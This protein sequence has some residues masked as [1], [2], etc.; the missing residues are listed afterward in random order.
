M[1]LIVFDWNPT[2]GL[3]LVAN[4]DEF[5]A[6]PSAALNW[7]AEQP[8]ILA[9]RDLQAG[10]SWLGL[11]RQGRFAAITNVREAGAETG[12]RSRGHLVR[13][14]LA[15]SSS[16]HVW[17]EDLEPQAYPGFNLLL[18]A[19]K[20]LVYISN[21]GDQGAQTLA[22]GLYGVSNARLDTPWPKLCAA[23]DGLAALPADAPLEDWLQI[24]SRQQPWPDTELP[25]TGVGVELERLLSPP[26]IRSPAYGTRCTTALHWQPTG[27]EILERRFDASGSALGDSHFQ[28]DF[29]AP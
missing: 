5:H 3:R 13:D 29:A 25:D 14:F 26:F 23:R 11:S 27:A 7:W 9:G 22:A 28:L 21:R 4:R 2:Q 1:C 18:L 8:Q 20:E 19:G 16:P 17:L 10:G 15:S 12:P 24:T 6:R